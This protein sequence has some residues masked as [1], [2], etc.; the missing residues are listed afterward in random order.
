MMAIHGADDLNVPITGG[1]GKGL[2]RVDFASQAATAKVWQDSGAFYDLRIVS[3][4]DHSVQSI[5]RQ[6]LRAES[7]NLAQTMARFFGLLER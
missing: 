6:L 2:A 7:Q 5:S 3:G 4:A 1:R